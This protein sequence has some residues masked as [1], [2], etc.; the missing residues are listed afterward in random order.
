MIWS[1]QRK[2]W[3]PSNGLNVFALIDPKGI[4][5]GEQ[6]YSLKTKRDLVLV[7]PFDVNVYSNGQCVSYIDSLFE[8][9]TG[10]RWSSKDI[11][12]FKKDYKSREP[13]LN[14][15]YADYRID[16]WIHPIERSPFQMEV[17]IFDSRLLI[18]TK[19]S[20]KL[21]SRVSILPGSCAIKLTSDIGKIKFKKIVKNIQRS[22]RNSWTPLGEF[23]GV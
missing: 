1:W 14:K 4:W 10:L 13:F 5:V 6:L 12:D 17:C 15:L 23:V 20:N 9:T 16:G 2:D 11:V 8:E 18:N 21:D 19:P 22:D 7:A 3:N